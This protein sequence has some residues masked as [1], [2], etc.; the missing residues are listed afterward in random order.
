MDKN[1]KQKAQKAART[2]NVL[3]QL[4]DIGTSTGKQMKEELLQKA[5]ASFMEQMFSP[6]IRKNYSGEIMAGEALE[7]KEVYTGQYQEKLKL[8]KQLSFERKLRK[9]EE[10]RI[11]K[12]AN[13]L[14]IQLNVLM[15]EVYEL[16]QATQD[17]GEETKLAA[18]QAP[19]EP[20]VYHV[21]FF[22][23]L[24][25]FIKSFRRKID[26]T[27]IWLKATNKRAEKK[28]YWSKYKKHGS[29]FLLSADH[30]LTRSAG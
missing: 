18:M 1:Q 8:Q 23:K 21:I 19:V 10:A 17:I 24:I 29:K 12:R 30:Y 7:L 2:A 5:P 4:K 9:E 28:N 11:E 22:E 6:G 16:S 3:E 25:E 26:E 14:K 15:K 27:V 20:G 13:E